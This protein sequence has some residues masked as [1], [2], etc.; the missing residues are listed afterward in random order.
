MTVVINE[1]E[2]IPETM[3][4]ASATETRET[5]TPPPVSAPEV[6]LLVDH[7]TARAMRLWA[8]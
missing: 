6:E 4:A 8:H 3:P 1:F 2:V 5:P 7:L